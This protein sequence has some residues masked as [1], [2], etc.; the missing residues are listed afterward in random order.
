ME[1]KE[2]SR[3]IVFISDR[4]TIRMGKGTIRKKSQAITNNYIALRSDQDKDLG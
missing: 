3:H 4:D 1:M 2:K